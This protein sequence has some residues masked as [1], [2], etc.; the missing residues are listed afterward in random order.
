MGC[1]DLCAIHLSFCLFLFLTTV[2]I[3][4]SWKNWELQ[5]LPT[6]CSLRMKESSCT[7]SLL[8]PSLHLSAGVSLLGLSYCALSSHWCPWRWC[9]GAQSGSWQGWTWTC[10]DLLWWTSWVQPGTWG[11]PLSIT[12][13]AVLGPAGHAC[14]VIPID[15]GVDS[16]SW[17]FQELDDVRGR[18]P[19]A[20]KFNH[21]RPFLVFHPQEA[22]I[23]M[24]EC[25]DF[26]I[27]K[28]YIY[29]MQ[30]P[31]QKIL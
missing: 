29:S 6:Q 19:C 10:L 22:L 21:G 17:V 13:W 18:V 8:W 27:K 23:A 12:P 1:T 26:F 16:V 9:W 11:G 31:F 5:M 30:H 28:C 4:P 24:N 25:Y 20:E 7:W 15:D 2:K 3:F 14:A